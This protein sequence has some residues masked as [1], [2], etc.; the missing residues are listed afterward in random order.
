MNTG[1]KR[2]LVFSI[3]LF[4]LLMCLARQTTDL[5]C[6]CNMPMVLTDGTWE[7]VLGLVHTS[8]I[9]AIHS[10]IQCKILHCI[11]YSN[12]RLAR[13]FPGISDACHRCGQSPADLVWTCPLL[14]EF[15]TDILKSFKDISGVDVPSDPLT[16]LFSAPPGTN[17]P[18]YLYG[19]MSFTS[20]LA[21]RLI[22]IKWN[23]KSPPTHNRCKM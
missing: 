3:T 9:C 20:L 13:I 1:L 18:L 5:H 19:I 17:T 23:Y 12:V 7:T 15:W 22:L 10:L 4:I 16:A 11:H 8:S 14:S 21:R 2:G 6:L